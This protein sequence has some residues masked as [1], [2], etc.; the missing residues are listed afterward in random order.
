[1]PL[2]E[3]LYN[4]AHWLTQS[5]EEAEDLVQETYAKGLKGFGTFQPGSNFRAWMFRI[6]RNSFLTSRSG[7]KSMVPLEDAE[8]AQLL[9]SAL[10]T[11]ETLALG[12]ED[13]ELVRAALEQLPVAYREVVL[14]CDWEQMSYSDIAGLLGIP[15]GTVMSRISRARRAMRQFLMAAYRLPDAKKKSDK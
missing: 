3:P 1:M 2:L 14:L 5:R 11:P 4:F 13:E 6:L 7:L 10:E 8:E 12:R 15:I 9:P